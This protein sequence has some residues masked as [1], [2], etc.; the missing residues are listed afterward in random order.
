MAGDVAGSG[1]SWFELAD[2]HR[3]LGHW[4]ARGWRGQGCFARLP[5]F[6]RT[7]IGMMHLH[8]IEIDA[9]A[10]NRR[11]RAVAVRLG[12]TEEATLRDG[13]RDRTAP[14]STRWCSGPRHRREARVT[15]EAWSSICSGRSGS[16][17]QVGLLPNGTAPSGGASAPTPM[18]SS[19]SGSARRSPGRPGGSRT[20]KSNVPRHLRHARRARRRDG[21]AFRPRT[22]TGP[23]YQTWF[24]P[25][26]GVLERRSRR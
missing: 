8:R 5:A 17:F 22:E 25:R 12:F 3:E 10:D 18:G 9:A 11:S 26:R 24:R 7:R 16:E 13:F 6:H 19:R 14:T 4:V 20:S 15:L 2:E 21:V 1:V 23:C